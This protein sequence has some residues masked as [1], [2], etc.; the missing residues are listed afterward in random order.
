MKFNRNPVEP[1]RV[2]SKFGPR[3]TG[4]KGASTDHKGVDLGA[5]RALAKTPAILTNK[6]KVITNG[7]NALRGWYVVAQIDN[8]YSV[9]Y[10]HL[11]SQ[12]PLVKGETYPAGTQVGIIG[13][14]RDKSKIPTM[15]AHLHFEVW[16]NKVPINPA[17][18]LN[19][20]EEEEM[21]K[22]YKTLDD[23]P[24]WGKATIEKVIRAGGITPAN[25]NIDLTHSM[26]RIYVSLDKMQ[27]L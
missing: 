13:E 4:I 3:N 16:K 11:E 1:V 18:Y 7:W 8:I 20:L 6:A 26:L 23:V 9:L 19:N 12:S 24:A 14:S 17:P 21:E 27:K 2:T 25:G 5:N 10:Q 15:S 22:T